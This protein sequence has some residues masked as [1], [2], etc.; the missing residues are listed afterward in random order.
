M[1]GWTGNKYFSSWYQRLLKHFGEN[2]VERLL[3]ATKRPQFNKQEKKRTETQTQQKRRNQATT[4][5]RRQR[6]KQD[7][8]VFSCIFCFWQ[9]KN[10]NCPVCI[11]EFLHYSSASLVPAAPS[12]WQLPAP[13]SQCIHTH[14]Q[15]HTNK[16]IKMH[17][18]THTED[19]HTCTIFL[20]C[21]VAAV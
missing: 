9:M 17:P 10:V 8:L 3:S 16:S 21:V 15:T 12:P 20:D 6:V 19:I 18:H 11:W 1:D 7:P 13:C 2:Q 14:T 4:D 5:T